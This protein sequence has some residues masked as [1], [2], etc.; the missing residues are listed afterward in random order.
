[1]IRYLMIPFFILVGCSSFSKVESNSKGSIQKET[2]PLSGASYVNRYLFDNGLRLL[3]VEDHSSP[4]IA[5]QTWFRVGS[6]DETP[7]RTGLAH[8]FEHM[9]FKETKNLKEGEF[10]KL[11]EGAG[12]EGEN[13][14]TD[15]DFT[16]YIQELPKDK[17]ELIAK[18]ESDRMNNLVIN[19]NAF[20]TER[21][22][23]QN[24]RRFRNENSPDGLMDQELFSLAFVQH[25]YHWPV[26]GYTEDL[27]AMTSKEALEFYHTHYSPNH[28]TIIVTGDVESEN[29]KSIIQKYYGQL[30][31]QLT[32]SHLIQKEPAQKK[33]RRKQLKLNIQVEKLMMG[34]HIPEI[35]HQDMPALDVLQNIL[36]RGKSSRLYRALVNT[37]VASAITS[38]DLEGKDPSLF[39]FI[40]NMQNKKNTS[41]AEAII[42]KEL[43]RICN[44]EISKQE[45][46]RAKNKMNFD[47][48]EA[49]GSNFEKAYFLG[50]Y[51]SAAGD[52]TKG[53]EHNK[54]AQRV[55]AQ[56]V[57][58]VARRYLKPNNLTVVTGVP[59]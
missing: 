48:F 56:D 17:L 4:T 9:M 8:L 34:F 49:L 23:V 33:L 38:D 2:I 22:V 11:L 20:K 41:Q 19:E 24:E 42:R 7:G 55:S 47:F 40:A 31:A 16:A 35:T 45:L 5:Y 13:A 27:N 36:T 3:V 6:R 25:P 37:G 1:M 12:A 53:I 18:A 15:H 10:D 44:E 51:E 14:F 58:D 59:K 32:H 21:E 26:I 43:A 52:F 30:P 28:A 46:E 50:H 54:Q 57:R 29:V 39:V